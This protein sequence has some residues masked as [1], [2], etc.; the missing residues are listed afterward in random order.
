MALWSLMNPIKDDFR[1]FLFLCWKHLN[2]PDPTPVQYDMANFIQH[3]PKR[4]VIQA[5]RGVGKSWICSAFVCWKLLNDPDLK[6]LVVS[7][8]KNRAD[9]FST[10][11]KRLISEMEILQHLSPK[12][13]QRGSN[14][15]FDV[16][17]A[18]AS[19]A[20]SVKSVGIT[21]QHTGSRANDIVRG[22]CER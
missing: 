18:K 3:A 9:D 20:P 4:A 8:S 7:A 14:V 6:F 1:N 2:L 5:F 12:D 13:N 11:T 22:D 16:A 10:F 21:G 19:H 17:L 15:S